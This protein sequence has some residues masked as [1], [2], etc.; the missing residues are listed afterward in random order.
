MY[1]KK[2]KLNVDGSISV[3]VNRKF[4]T[5][6]DDGYTKWRYLD[7]WTE[8]FTGNGQGCILDSVSDGANDVV[9]DAGKRQG[10]ISVERERE[11]R[12]YVA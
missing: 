2:P 12:D 6:D 10:G 9:A 5:K 11:H 1:R 7:G 8:N 4:R 3:Y